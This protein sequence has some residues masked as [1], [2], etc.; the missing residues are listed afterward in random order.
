MDRQRQAMG[1]RNAISPEKGMEEAN[2][3]LGLWPNEGTNE[4]FLKARHRK[5][6]FFHSKISEIP[7]ATKKIYLHLRT[8]R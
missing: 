1:R 8:C 5:G 2:G 6:F 7:F 4:P 3:P